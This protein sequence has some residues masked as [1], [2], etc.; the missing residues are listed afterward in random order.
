M[1]PSDTIPP[2]I[3][4]LSP[5]NKTYTANDVPLSFLVN[6]SASWI[7][8]SLDGQA[9]VTIAGNTTLTGLSDGSHSVIVY[10]NDTAG[11]IGSSE[12]IYFSISTQR[13]PFPIWIV[14]VIVIVAAFGTA[15][16]L[17]KIRKSKPTITKQQSFY[18]SNIMH[19]KLS[20]LLFELG[21]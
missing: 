10:A 19:G 14:A 9:N 2:A 16:Y 11:N 1:I 20:R 8:Y 13:E 3:S 15:V 12:M 6:E 21:S 18:S 17:L 5:E 7:I 4:I